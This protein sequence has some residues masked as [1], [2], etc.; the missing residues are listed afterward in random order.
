MLEPKEVWE[1]GEQIIGAV[2]GLHVAQ[3]GRG[4]NSDCG[5]NRDR[6]QSCEGEAQ[7]HQAGL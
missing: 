3:R 6:S 5:I 7:P 2:E 1:I 4:R